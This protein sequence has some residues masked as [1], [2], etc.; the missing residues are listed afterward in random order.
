MWMVNLDN[1]NRILSV[2]RETCLVVMEGGVRLFDLREKLNQHGLAMGNLGSIDEQS[3]AGAMATATHGSSL[4]HGLLTESILA[5]RIMLANGEILFCS[6]DEHLDLFRAALVSLGALGI[7]I[8]VTYRAVPAFDIEWHQS[9]HPLNKILAAWEGNLWSQTEFVRVWW[10]P[11]TKRA[12]LWKAEKTDKP[13]RAAKISW[14]GSLVGFHTYHNLLYLARWFPCLLPA[15]EWFVF[16]MQYGFWTGSSASAVQEGQSGLLMDCLF[17]QFVNEWG[18]PLHKGPEAIRRLSDW[19]HGNQEASGIP[20]SPKGIYIHAPIEVRVSD[21]SSTSIRPLLDNTATEGPTLYFNATLYR[22]Y[23]ADPPGRERFYAAFEYLMKEL[24]GRPHW[25]KNFSTLSPEDFSTMYGTNLEEWK[26]IRQDVDPEGMFIGDW[27]RRYLLSEHDE[28][29]ELEEKEIQQS[30][31]KDGG[32]VV[33]GERAAR[34]S[35][36]SSSS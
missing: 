5:L 11:Y 34:G 9:L 18:I 7:I 15:I 33:V 27:H 17:S 28:P 24:G 13:R 23:H 22:P 26:R 14:Y 3:I 19:I 6:A 10:L 35:S 2:D 21:T 12:I 1:Y 16:G 31:H 32:W 36:S 8:E 20:I 4:K 25:A 30:R 29:L